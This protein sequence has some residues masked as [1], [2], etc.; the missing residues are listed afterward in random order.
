MSNL[1][2][3]NTPFNLQVKEMT[4]LSEGYNIIGLSQVI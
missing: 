3:N 4:E 2:L 1:F